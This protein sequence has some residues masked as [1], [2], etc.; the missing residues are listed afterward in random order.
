MS[1]HGDDGLTRIVRDA[2][3]LRPM[4]LAGLAADLVAS[5][6]GDREPG[7]PVSTQML[8]SHHDDVI[9]LLWALAPAILGL[10][11]TRVIRLVPAHHLIRSDFRSAYGRAIESTFDAMLERG[12]TTAEQR[13]PLA[14]AIGI[15]QPAIADPIHDAALMLH[16]DAVRRRIANLQGGRQ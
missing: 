5:Q 11:T 14:I 13:Q 3:A 4:A 9:A 12:L 15:T 2:V 8:L 7:R 16:P 10:R 6:S 1:A